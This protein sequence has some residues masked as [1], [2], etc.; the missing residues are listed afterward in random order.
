MTTTCSNIMISIPVAPFGKICSGLVLWLWYVRSKVPYVTFLDIPEYKWPVVRNLQ[1]ARFLKVR[2]KQD[3]LLLVDSDM[4]PPLNVLDM[5]KNKKEFCTA[6]NFSYQYEVPFAQVLCKADD[7]NYKQDEKIL[8]SPPG[9]YEID[10]CGL[11]C[12]L[13]S[14]KMVEDMGPTFRE[15][16]AADGLQFYRDADFDF[17]ERAKVKGYKLFVDTRFISDHMKTIRLK[18]FNNILV[19]NGR[20]PL[21][22]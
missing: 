6:V 4:V 7:G 21:V 22:G 18:S 2:P 1:F 12:C 11:A 5:V 9:L 8:S 17:C 3:Y 20:E 13:I 19:K 15:P 10:V 16:I 14:R